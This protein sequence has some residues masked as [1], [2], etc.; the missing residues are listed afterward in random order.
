MEPHNSKI[1]KILRR[2]KI[3][4][5]GRGKIDQEH[6]E[7]E[8]DLVN[9]PKEVKKEVLGMNLEEATEA[10]EETTIERTMVEV[11]TETMKV[12]VR[13]KALIMRESNMAAT[14]EEIKELDMKAEVVIK[15]QEETS[16]EETTGTDIVVEITE[17]TIEVID[18]SVVDIEEAIEVAKIT[19][20]ATTKEEAL[21][22]T[23]VREK[24]ALETLS[25]KKPEMKYTVASNNSSRK[26][27]KWQ[28]MALK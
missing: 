10:T 19:G 22:I 27:L 8:K 28:L 7:E 1:S 18:L 2:N 14:E 17:V 3:S 12:M 6:T 20:A 16:E 25:V 21:A 5:Q 23:R 4:A 9:L 26:L 11:I 24:L 15:N 13:I